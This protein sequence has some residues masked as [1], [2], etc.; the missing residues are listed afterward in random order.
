M[1]VISPPASFYPDLNGLRVT[2]NDPMERVRWRT[3]Q[4]LDYAFL[5][6]YAQSRGVYYVQLEDDILTTPDY[7][8]KMMRF[9]LDK[10]ASKVDWFL[11]D[12]CQLGFIGTGYFYSGLLPIHIQYRSHIA[13]SLSTFFP[14]C[15]GKMFRS[16]DLPYVIQFAVMFHNDKPVDWLLDPI[17][18]TRY[19]PHD[20]V[21][22]LTSSSIVYDSFTAH[23]SI[24]Q[25]H[26]S[27]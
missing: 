10:E 22:T 20:T 15:L 4:N 17:L 1:E 2:L 3:K 25:I 19:C 18:E 5:M 12:F 13:F 26:D 24:H 27:L 11:L 6:M 16:V 14:F 23:K 9:A 8:S 7:V 21:R